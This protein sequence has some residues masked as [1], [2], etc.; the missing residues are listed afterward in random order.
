ME[1][2]YFQKLKYYSHMEREKIIHFLEEIGIPVVETELPDDCFLPGLAL[3]KNTILMDPERMRFPGDLLHEAG[4]LAV[5]AV[6]E[7]KLIGTSE[8]DPAWPT[9]GDEIAAILWSYAAL[10]HLNIKPEVVFHPNGYKNQSEWLITTFNAEN[11]IGLPLL[12]WM[13]LCNS[14]GKA[15]LEGTEAFPKMIKWLR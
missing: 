5:T 4:H 8:M 12:E 13:G 1:F 15:K 14:P 3:E 2:L 10:Q 7:R 9:E 6:E 11:Y